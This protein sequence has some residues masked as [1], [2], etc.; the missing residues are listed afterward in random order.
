MRSIWLL[1]VLAQRTTTFEVTAPQH[2]IASN[3]GNYKCLH[4]CPIARSTPP[5]LNWR[6]NHFLSIAQIFTIAQLYTDLM[7]EIKRHI[8][9]PLSTLNFLLYNTN[10]SIMCPCDFSHV[11][12]ANPL[13]FTH[14]LSLARKCNN[15]FG[16]TV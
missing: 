11:C 14:V 4:M 1:L 8:R 5:T 16:Y 6:H 7:Q 13:R 3:A 12:A 15:C 2:D 9:S 10:P